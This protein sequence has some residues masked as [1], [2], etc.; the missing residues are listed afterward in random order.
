MCLTMEVSGVSEAQRDE[1]QAEPKSKSQFKRM[2]AQGWNPMTDKDPDHHLYRYDARAIVRRKDD[3][4]NAQ[5]KEALDWLIA[6]IKAQG[7]EHLTYYSD[8]P[9]YLKQRLEGKK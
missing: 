4:E 8:C 2:T 1:E 7:H 3:I 5:A 9:P 6:K